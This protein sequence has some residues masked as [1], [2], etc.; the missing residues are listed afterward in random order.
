MEMINKVESLIF[1][2]ALNYPL[3]QLIQNK[4]VIVN[5]NLGRKFHRG[6]LYL[7]DP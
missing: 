4:T 1:K 3:I 5:T 6:V 2:Q 7:K